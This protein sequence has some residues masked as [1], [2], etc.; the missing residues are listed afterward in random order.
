MESQ[1]YASGGRSTEIIYLSKGTKVLTEN[2]LKVP[3]VQV[4]IMQNGTIYINVHHI[5]QL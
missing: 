2:I 1:L 3:K 5:I 4:L